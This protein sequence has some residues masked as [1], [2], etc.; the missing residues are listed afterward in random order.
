MSTT[1]K[2]VTPFKRFVPVGKGI[3]QTSI[4]GV[5]FDAVA[6]TVDGVFGS[7]VQRIFSFNFPMIGPIGVIDAIN[8]L[9][10]GQG[11]I[12]SGKGLTAVLAAKLVQTGG[13]A[14]FNLIPTLRGTPSTTVSVAG[15]GPTTGTGANI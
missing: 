2:L 12:I 9:I 11:K 13:I 6:K 10:H 4:T 14:G 5:G 8:Y 7:P 15:Q 1:T 3:V